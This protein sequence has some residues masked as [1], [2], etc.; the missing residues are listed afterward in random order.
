MSLV[1]NFEYKVHDRANLHFDK[2]SKLLESGHTLLDLTGKD[3]AAKCVNTWQYFVNKK[4]S[5]E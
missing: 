3:L 1:E 2:C 5:C 4:M